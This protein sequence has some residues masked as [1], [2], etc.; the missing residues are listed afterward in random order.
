MTR[1]IEAVIEFVD[2][3]LS[4]VDERDFCTHSTIL[5]LEKL[6]DKTN[7]SRLLFSAFNLITIDLHRW[8]KG[9]TISSLSEV[10]YLVREVVKIYIEGADTKVDQTRDALSDY[11]EHEFDVCEAVKRNGPL[12]KVVGLVLMVG[13]HTESPEKMA[14]DFR[15]QCKNL[16]AA[17]TKCWDSLATMNERLDTGHNAIIPLNN[18][19]LRTLAHTKLA[20]TCLQLS[21]N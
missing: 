10:P 15:T 16:V 3:G 19:V 6:K 17:T 14:D 4:I 7:G 21:A 11:D 5:R 9:L 20:D 12:E 1:F 18:Y 13:S 8:C 2:E